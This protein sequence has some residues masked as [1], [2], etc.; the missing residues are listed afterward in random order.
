MGGCT[1]PGIKLNDVILEPTALNEGSTIGETT[2]GKDK[3]FGNVMSLIGVLMMSSVLQVARADNG[4]AD[5]DRPIRC[6][7]NRYRAR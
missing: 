1:L 6:T 5:R 3:V 2:N 7:R 4:T